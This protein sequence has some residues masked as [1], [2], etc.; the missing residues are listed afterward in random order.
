MCKDK[1][2]NLETGKPAGSVC[3]RGMGI[4]SPAALAGHP[5]PQG[6]DH[7]TPRFPWRR[8]AGLLC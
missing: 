2:P 6:A 8:T 1:F 7:G 3:N 5:I 4:P